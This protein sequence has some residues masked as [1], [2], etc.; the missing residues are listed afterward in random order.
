M[1][2]IK[3]VGGISLA[4][5]VV[6]FSLSSSA[7]A[8]K[9]FRWVDAD[10]KVHYS[11]TLPPTASQQGYS[12]INET[13]RQVGAVS[14]IVEQAETVDDVAQE[15]TVEEEA[16]EAARKTY[17]N[18]LLAS[19][20]RID[21]LTGVHLKKQKVFHDQIELYNKRIAKL[22]KSL[23]K[24]EKQEKDTKNKASKTK[25]KDYIAVTN[26]SIK[27]YKEM[28]IDNQKKLE[29]LLQT[30][31]SDKS[32]LVELLSRVDSKEEEIVKSAE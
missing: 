30:Y 13:G 6:L 5:L 9:Y 19:Y 17:D 31:Q 32:R 4:V 3:A 14:A 24:V 20:L 10:G 12:K 2:R 26:D 23:T 27:V 8:A 29:K 11:Y 18:Y 15:K 25:L 16:V 28:I 1:K 21:E 7:F 22:E